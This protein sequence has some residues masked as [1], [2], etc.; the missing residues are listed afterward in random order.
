MVSHMKK[1]NV[2][3]AWDS[4]QGPWGKPNTKAQPKKPAAETPYSQKRQP[5]LEDVVNSMAEKLRGFWKSSNGGGGT[6]GPGSGTPFGGNGPFGFAPAWIATAAFLLY[7][8]TGLYVIAPEEQGVVTRFGAYIKTT[9]SGLNYHLPWPLERVYKLPV[10]RVNQLEVGFR[11]GDNG[12]EPM[13]VP[14]ESLMLTGDQNIV[15]LDFTVNWKIYNPSAVL[16][17]VADPQGTLVDVAQSVMRETLGQHT[18][19]DVLTTNKSAIQHEARTHMQAVL[20]SYKMG[21][22]V[23]NVSLQRVNPPEEVVEAFRDV[24]TANADKQRLINEARGYANQIVPIARGEAAKQLEQA[25]GYKQ[26]K[27]AEATGAAERFNVQVGAY[28]QA[29]QVTKDRLY[30]ETMQE[31]LQNT[32]KVVTTSRNATGAVPFLPLNNLIKG[33]AK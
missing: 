22:Q 28:Q 1:Q 19:D 3:L 13:D 16:F 7:L 12:E 27:V 21:I 14:T 4:G 31:V 30:F 24:Q 11:S 29:P 26:A 9:D 5:E 17:N 8:A 33:E 23:V 18:V 25:A 20:D 6:G 32:P 10:T 2:T 15:D